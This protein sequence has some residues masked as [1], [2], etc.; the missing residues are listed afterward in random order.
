MEEEDSALISRFLSSKQA[1]G[2]IK[3][4]YLTRIE[5]GVSAAKQRMKKKSSSS[6]SDPHIHRA[7]ILSFE[8]N[9]LFRALIDCISKCHSLEALTIIG[10][11]IP[12][13]FLAALGNAIYQND[14]RLF[15]SLVIKNNH[16]RDEGL[17][18]LT[19]YLAKSKIQVMILENLNLT[20]A[21]CSYL[22][23]ILKAQEAAMDTLYWNSTLRVD[24]ALDDGYATTDTYGLQALSLRGNQITSS[25][26]IYIAKFLRSNQWLLSVNFACNQIDVEGVVHLC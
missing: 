12:P 24:S 2:G 3:A 26:V 19:P 11:H 4:I 6:H 22:A 5:H 17:R 13:E 20:D 23:S 21:S 9:K 1:H 10:V 16:L 7:S 18:I 25:G 14:S 8:N 15:R